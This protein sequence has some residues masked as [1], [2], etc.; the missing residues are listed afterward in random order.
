MN[1]LFVCTGN[2]SR[3][4]LAEV[5]LRREIQTK[6]LKGSSVASAGL[7]AYPG[8]PPDPVIV[9]YLEERGVPIPRHEARTMT[10][11]DTEWADLILVMEK[12]HALMIEQWW[13]DAKGKVEL[14]LK[15]ALLDPG[16][17]EVLDPF[18]KTTY[19]YRLAETQIEMAVKSLAERLQ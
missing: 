12:G 9:N 16:V 19:H 3:S 10:K 7:D 6:S 13:P 17:D 5:L 18:G 4:F 2:I 15:Y 11:R 14:L 8:S 1:I